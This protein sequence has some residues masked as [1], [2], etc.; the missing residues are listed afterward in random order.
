MIKYINEGF[1]SKLVFEFTP[2][3]EEFGLHV[4]SEDVANGVYVKPEYI[5]SFS[6][7]ETTELIKYL[8][9]CLLD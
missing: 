1:A 3:T 2:L 4:Y 6:K 8:Q 5:T 7:E 9:Y